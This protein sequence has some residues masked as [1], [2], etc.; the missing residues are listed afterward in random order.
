[1]DLIEFI[2]NEIDE[3]TGEVVETIPVL[4]EETSIALA[5][6]EKK[7]KELK[8]QEEELKQKILEEMEGKGILKVDTPELTIT[9]KAPTTRESLDSKTL[10]AELPDIYD[11]YVK[12][13]PV[14]G[15]ITIKVK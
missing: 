15:S 10:K 1:M 6:F 12:I 7:I 14:K 11:T 8:E 3:V 2:P 4:K 5:T 9:R 13:S